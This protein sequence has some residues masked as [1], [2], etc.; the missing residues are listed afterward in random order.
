MSVLL[1]LETAKVCEGRVA[2]GLWKLKLLSTL[3]FTC[4]LE[5]KHNKAHDIY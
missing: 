3:A 1:C 4:S 5:A 2:S